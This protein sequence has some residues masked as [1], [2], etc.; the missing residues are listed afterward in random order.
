[1]TLR[2]LPPER[3]P[4]VLVMS[5]SATP[6]DVAVL[7]ALGAD[8]FVPKNETLFSAVGH[9]LGDVRR[10]RRPTLRPSTRPP[11]LVA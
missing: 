6:R 4:A 7:R 8:A 2:S 1:M 3:R 9:A 5:G 11:G 10:T